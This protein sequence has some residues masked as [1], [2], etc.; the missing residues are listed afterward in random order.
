MPN[1]LRPAIRPV[2]GR[3]TDFPINPQEGVGVANDATLQQIAAQTTDANTLFPHGVPGGMD[4]YDGGRINR[5]TPDTGYDWIVPWGQIYR[6]ESAALNPD[7]V[8][9]WRNLTLEVLS[10]GV[11]TQLQSQLRGTW[12]L[13]TENPVG[14]HTRPEFNFS[15][16][17]NP[18]ISKLVD[19]Y[20][21]HFYPDLSRASVPS[22][23]EGIIVSFEAKV[24]SLSGADI[25]VSS[26]NK[27][28]ASTGC[29]FWNSSSG[30]L[31]QDSWVGSFTALTPSYRKFYGSTLS[32]AQL[33]ANPPPA[34][35]NQISQTDAQT[36]DPD[37]V[38]TIPSLAATN[39]LLSPND[40]ANAGNWTYR[41]SAVLT[42]VTADQYVSFAGVN[43]DQINATGAET[44]GACRNNFEPAISSGVQ[45]VIAFK[46]KR[47]DLT[48]S[49]Y[50]Q[51]NQLTSGG[52]T[53]AA[54]AAY[55]NY[56]TGEV[57][58]GALLSTMTAT[59]V[60]E[61]LPQDEIACYL[62]VTG[63]ATSAKYNVY[64][65]HCDAPGSRANTTGSSYIW[66]AYAA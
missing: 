13:Y 32:L 11:W 60:F 20:M 36:L 43:A 62:T 31:N 39:V 48:K 65:G 61:S 26:L 50:I 42:T 41:Q 22:P 51:I 15:N 52:S 57:T 8:V 14:N 18:L 27:I 17:P 47:K 7:L 45:K 38:N 59:A 6:E 44:E 33:R 1:V 9:K 28:I 35:L 49:A 64:L 56:D 12:S 63:V 23:L 30:G 29:D 21:L 46:F 54:V 25:S 53:L 55:F 3:V 40:F 58:Y 16:A 34:S 2:I 5:L 24:E 66:D 37:I 19:G 4:W 10:N